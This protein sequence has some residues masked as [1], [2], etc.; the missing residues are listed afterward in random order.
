MERRCPNCGE[1]PG[2]G[3]F[4]QH[5]GARQPEIVEGTQ[6]DPGASGPVEESSV[7]PPEGLPPEDATPAAPPPEQAT[8]E[9]PP[10]EAQVSGPPPDTPPPPAAPPSQPAPTGEPAATPPIVPAG[11]QRSGCRT[12]CLVTA[13][14][15]VAIVAV[16]G[17]FAWRWIDVEFINPPTT[18]PSDFFA[19]EELP[20]GPCYDLDTEGGFLTGWTEVSCDGPRPREGGRPS[21]GG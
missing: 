4:C 11:T 19:F 14:V 16:G 5:C 10:P 6:S 21:R 12:G 2:V 20:P 3:T 1:D 15:V 18:F 13:I 9:A 8:P 7:P 17:F